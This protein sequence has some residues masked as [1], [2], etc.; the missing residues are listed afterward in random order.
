[1]LF[2][3]DAYCIVMMSYALLTTYWTNLKYESDRMQIVLNTLEYPLCRYFC[4]ENGLKSAILGEV[5]SYRSRGGPA[6]MRKNN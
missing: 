1:M 6:L 4:M 3:I 5:T 2:G